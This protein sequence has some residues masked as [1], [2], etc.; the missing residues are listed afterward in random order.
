MTPEL[1]TIIVT[2][3]IGVIIAIIKFVPRRKNS[4]KIEDALGTISTDIGL[5]K[6]DIEVIKTNETNMHSWVKSLSERVTNL[7]KK[8]MDMGG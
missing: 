4:T 1:T 5:I 7:E 6:T 3:M 2:G 8:Q